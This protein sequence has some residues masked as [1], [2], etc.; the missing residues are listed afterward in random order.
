MKKYEI[1]K[2]LV[3]KGMENP[4]SVVD[5]R[6]G[7]KIAQKELDDHILRIIFEEEKDTSVIITVY[8]ARSERYGV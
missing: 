2:S 1:S 8:K 5:G 6:S 7:R 3:R 4:D